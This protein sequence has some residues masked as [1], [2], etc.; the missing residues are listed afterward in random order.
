MLQHLYDHGRLLPRVDT[1]RIMVSSYLVE[2]WSGILPVHSTKSLVL[3][4]SALHSNMHKQFRQHTERR[5]PPNL[6]EIYFDRRGLCL[7]LG[8]S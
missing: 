5:H 3:V 1:A 8:I 4:W 6:Q 7:S 2:K